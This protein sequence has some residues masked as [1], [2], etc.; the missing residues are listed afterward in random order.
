MKQHNLSKRGL[1]ERVRTALGV[2]ALVAASVLCSVSSADAVDVGTL[3]S[4]A[5][6][7][8]RHVPEAVRNGVALRVGTM[9]QNQQLKLAINLPQRNQADLDQLLQQLYDPQ[10]PNFGKYLTT[11]EFTARFGPTESDYDAVIAWAKANGL[12][13][14]ATTPNRRIV[15]VEGTVASINKALNIELKTY[16]HP[17]EDRIFFAPDPEPTTLAWM[18]NCCRSSG[19]TT[20]RCRR[21][22]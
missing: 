10:S 17:V 3:T 9:N 18:C 7:H 21:R 15:N 13:V 2:T 16:Q 5:V 19:S 20:S 1:A 14:V 22:T 11:E 8:A 4:H 6:I 12:N